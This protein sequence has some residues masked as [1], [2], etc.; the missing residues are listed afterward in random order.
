MLTP[1]E[2]EKLKFKRSMKGY[3]V[4][5]V[6]D[7]MCE[8]SETLQEYINEVEFIRK[9]NSQLEFELEKYKEL[10]NTLSETL[11]IAKR[12][13]EEMLMNAKKEAQN[14]VEKA[15]LEAH[16]IKRDME[17]QLNELRLKKSNLENELLSFKTRVK[18]ILENQLSTIERI[19]LE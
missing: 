11:V 13:S 4:K 9:K 17:A 19:N 14:L 18:S 7:F 16:E 2:I 6:N 10:E 3:D 15:N 12:T 5:Q 1:I 8:V